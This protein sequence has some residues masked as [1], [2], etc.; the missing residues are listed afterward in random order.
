VADGDLRIAPIADASQ[1][2]AQFVALA[3]LAGVI[4]LT[5]AVLTLVPGFAFLI[6]GVP[7]GSALLVERTMETRA[8]LLTAGAIAAGAFLFGALLH[9]P[10]LFGERRVAAL[11]IALAT[12]AGALT[13]AL[14][15]SWAAG[16]VQLVGA[17]GTGA[18]MGAWLIGAGLIAWS[19]FAEE[20]MFRG[21]LQPALRRAWGV[22]AA[23][24]LTALAFAFVH[25]LGGW[26]DPVSL[27]N[28]FLAALWF[29]LL[30]LRYGGV[31]VPTLAH[32]GW[33][34]AEAMIFGVSPNPGIGS[35]GSLLDVDL[36]GSTL[37]GGSQDGLNASVSVTILL[38]LLIGRLALAGRIGNAGAKRMKAPR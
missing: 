22:P 27:L 3:A 34:G 1:R 6:G 29:G 12:G 15:L 10:I 18:G 2:E 36:Q 16:A 17:P 20:L 38:A 14:S 8:A 24:G 25:Y 7:A 19:A 33:N 28:I 32:I 23:L 26:R 4:A 31:L 37:L 13:A 11:A 30:A 9:R 5:W 21:L 35:Y